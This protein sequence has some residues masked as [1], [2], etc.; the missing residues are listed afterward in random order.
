M[1]GLA[2]LTNL[3][4]EQMSGE[5]DFMSAVIEMHARNRPKCA[6]SKLENKRNVLRVSTESRGWFFL[7]SA[8]CF[9]VGP[10]S[11]KVLS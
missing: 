8:L 11:N 9:T 4:L 3:K 6:G 5:C 7:H 10:F 2:S 1:E